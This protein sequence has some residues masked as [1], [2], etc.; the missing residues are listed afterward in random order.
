M[1]TIVV[2]APLYVDD[3][4]CSVCGHHRVAP[5]SAGL[6]IINTNSRIVTTWSTSANL[7]SFQVRPRS[8]W[9]KN[10]TFRAGINASLIRSVWCIA[11]MNS[12]FEIIPQ[13]Q[14]E[15]DLME[16]S[17]IHEHWLM[18]TDLLESEQRMP[19]SWMYYLKTLETEYKLL[20][21]SNRAKHLPFIYV[22]PIIFFNISHVR[23]LQFRN[24]RRL[25]SLKM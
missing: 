11:S 10:G 24:C 22:F 16:W 3:L 13:I 15:Y 20:D 14:A 9:F 21:C 17:G 8:D 2:D 4:V 19:S 7:G 5:V 1:V 25:E 12:L 23:F 18:I 6:V